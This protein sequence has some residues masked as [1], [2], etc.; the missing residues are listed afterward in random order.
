MPT[1]C[2]KSPDDRGKS[3]QG[4]EAQKQDEMRKRFFCSIFQG[5]D[6]R[7]W[8]NSLYARRIRTQERILC[9]EVDGWPKM[10]SANKS[11]KFRHESEVS[12]IRARRFFFCSRSRKENLHRGDYW[13]LSIVFCSQKSRGKNL[14]QIWVRILLPGPKVG[15]AKKSC[16]CLLRVWLISREQTQ[17]HR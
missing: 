2:N 7:W 5:N 14:K 9:W 11:R 3:R 8:E 12:V 17:K 10:R 1:K 15:F 6:D 13:C 16:S 4:R